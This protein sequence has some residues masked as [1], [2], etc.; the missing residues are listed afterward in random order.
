[1]HTLP[2]HDFKSVLVWYPVGHS[3]L[4]PG[5]ALLQD[6]IVV[7]QGDGEREHSSMSKINL[8]IQYMYF[9]YHPSPYSQDINNSKTTGP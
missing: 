7:L 1:M 5:I 6:P 8:D 4:K 2:S 3:Q 9:N